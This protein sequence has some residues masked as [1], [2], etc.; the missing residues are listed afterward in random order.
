MAGG[1]GAAE[2]A[3]R[4]FGDGNQQHAVSENDNTIAMNGAAVAAAV[5]PV[6][7]GGNHH[8]NNNN[9]GG[10]WGKG[11]ISKKRLMKLMK[12]SK[13]SKN[14]YN[15]VAMAG[16]AGVL[17]SVAVPAILLYLNQKVAKSSGKKSMKLR[18]SSR[19][20]RKNNNN[21]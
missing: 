10:S 4:V 1:E 18:R 8:E 13:I 7:V 19:M 15:N 5:E 6:K 12:Q 14:D 21:N 11:G 16:G 9:N 2:N 3:L 17:E 20:S